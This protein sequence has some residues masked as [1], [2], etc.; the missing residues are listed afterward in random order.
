MCW[1]AWIRRSTSVSIKL[2]SL[3]LTSSCSNCNLD[4]NI[5][6]LFLGEQDT[7][8]SLK[9]KGRLRNFAT[10]KKFAGNLGKKAFY[11]K[12]QQNNPKTCLI[13]RPK[14]QKIIFSRLKKKRMRI[15]WKSMWCTTAQMMHRHRPRKRWGHSIR[16]GCQAHY[17]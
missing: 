15:Q 6:T 16:W 5:K 1:K 11:M 17:W 13:L 4:N 9:W 10:N 2:L 3:D 14:T 8:L 7:C 12:I